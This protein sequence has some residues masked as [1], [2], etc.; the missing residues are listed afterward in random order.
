MRPGAVAVGR[1]RVRRR[2]ASPSEA[3]IRGRGPPEGDIFCGFDRARA[4]LVQRRAALNDFH[5]EPYED[6]GSFR[7][8]F[9]TL[10]L[11]SLPFLAPLSTARR[12]GRTI[13]GIQ[14]GLEVERVSTLMQV[15]APQGAWDL[16]AARGISCG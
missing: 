7:S 13:F 12:C 3:W 6:G 8:T 14:G 2:V 4:I 15:R 11:R 16:P 1:P 9:L 10:G 5:S